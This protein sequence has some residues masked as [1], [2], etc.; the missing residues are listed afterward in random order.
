MVAEALQSN[1][2]VQ[3]RVFTQ[4]TPTQSA[5]SEV[6]AKN[7]AAPGSDVLANRETA[8]SQ[9]KLPGINPLNS[10]PVVL[11]PRPQTIANAG[12]QP[13]PTEPNAQK[14]EPESRSKTQ[15][16]KS[17]LSK[18][19]DFIADAINP[20]P[21]KPTIK[22]ESSAF[23]E[24]VKPKSKTEST[25]ARPTPKPADD[26]GPKQLKHRIRDKVFVFHRN[27]NM[28]FDQDYRDETMLFRRLTLRRGSKDYEDVLAKD[29]QL[30]EF[31]EFGQI[32]IVWKNKV[33][34][35]VD[36]PPNR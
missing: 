28:W 12:P 19:I 29:P 31:F 27:I 5:E 2:L 32:T 23:A 15:T 33:Y 21:P 17:R 18:T 3:G 11:T 9:I 34:R 25:R 20:F 8:K 4:V 10:G 24:E 7:S 14:P 36:K 1:T 26:E 22:T 16:D 6:N 30:K 35:V 13:P